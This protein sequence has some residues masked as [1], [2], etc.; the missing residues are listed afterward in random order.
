MRRSRSLIGLTLVTAAVVLV[1]AGSGVLFALDNFTAA[2]RTVLTVRDRQVALERVLSIVRDAETG[3][4]GFLLTQREPYL[5]PYTAALRAMEPLLVQ[6]ADLLADDPAQ[7]K[8]LAEVETQVRRKRAELAETVELMRSGATDAALDVV[9]TNAGKLLMDD[10]RDT[11]AQM[12]AVEDR[13]AAEALDRTAR[14]RTIALGSVAA[15]T[16][17]ALMMLV[18]LLYVARRSFDQ[19]RASQQRLAITLRSIGDAVVTTDAIGRVEMLNPVAERLTGWATHEA[20]GKPMHDVFRIINEH[21][22]AEVE[23]PVEKVLRDGTIVGLANHTLLIARDGVETPIEDAAAPIVDSHGHL[24][25]VVLVFRDASA[26][27]AAERSLLEADRRKN[28]FLAVLAH[29]LRNPLAPIRHAAL[30]ARSG[31]ATP[32]QIAW[33]NDVI[34]RQVGHMARLLDDLLDISRITRGTLEIRR[35]TVALA[36]IVE[37]AVEMARPLFDARRHTLE[38]ELPAEPLWLDADPLRIAQVLGNLLTNAAKFT[39]VG[40][41]ITLTAAREG[42]DVALSVTD[43]GIGLAP[44]TLQNIFQMFVQAAPPLERT[45]SGLG[46]GLALAKALVDLHG[47]QITAE[48]DGVGH[49]TTIRVRLPLAA[50]QGDESAAAPLTAARDEPAENPGLV[51]IADDNRDAADSFA[52]LLRLAGHRV[53]TVNDGAA[54]IAEIERSRPRVA[55]LDIGMPGKTGYDVAAHVRAQPWGAEIALVATTGWGQAT[56][57]AHALAVGFDEHWVKPVDATRAIEFCNAKLASPR[58]Q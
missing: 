3:Q 10:I 17:L 7:Q 38:V 11:I 16:A 41:R 32:A 57:R 18:V 4:R 50:A 51:L 19:I 42:S 13:Q 55:L 45:E 1:T 31:H 37:D 36:K 58:P 43:S 6:L 26:A 39:D 27:R 54:A 14:G 34:E 44:E 28:E 56:D 25:G 23:N 49:G 2:N 5:E 24:H 46:I 8:A 29:E 53:V 33:G 40:G 21:T 12:Q 22:R 9:L 35:T 52:A 30:I 20:A 48:S 15:L 47:G